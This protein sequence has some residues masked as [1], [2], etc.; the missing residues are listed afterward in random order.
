[1]KKARAILATVV[2]VSLAAVPAA[3]ATDEPE[4]S[5]AVEPG[6]LGQSYAEWS[7]AWQQWNN[8]IG[9]GN[10]IADCAVGDQG[11]VFFLPQWPGIDCTIS[12][13]QHVLV[14][15]AAARCHMLGR[16]N[17]DAKGKEFKAQLLGLGEMTDCA[18][19]RATDIVTEP[20]LRVDGVNVS[21]DDYWTVATPYASGGATFVNPGYIVMLTPLAVGSHLIESGYIEPGLGAF[22]WVANVEVIDQ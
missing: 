17:A 20:Y 18:L 16:L 6:P 8:E 12:S 21:L 9:G 15:V 22:D 3:G 4:A 10:P 7:A 1:M 13:E 11:E 14:L 5:I 2:C 19:L